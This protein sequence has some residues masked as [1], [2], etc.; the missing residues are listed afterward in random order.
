[1]A[2]QRALVAELETERVLVEAN[3]EL[4]L[5]FEQKLQTKLSEIWGAPSPV[6]RGSIPAPWVLVVKTSLPTGISAQNHRFFGISQDFTS[7]K[8]RLQRCKQSFQH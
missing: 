2:E 5:R 7:C 8:R 6:I 1:M 4:A 3:R